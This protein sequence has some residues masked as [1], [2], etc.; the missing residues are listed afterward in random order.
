MKMSSVSS[1]GNVVNSGGK[2]YEMYYESKYQ[3]GT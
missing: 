2:Q 1:S 3:G